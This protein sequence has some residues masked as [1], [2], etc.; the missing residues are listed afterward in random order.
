MGHVS[1]V[2]EPFGVS[3]TFTYDL[4][5]NRISVT[6]NLGGNETSTY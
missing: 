5:G 2:D 6:D 4:A 3:L 1:H